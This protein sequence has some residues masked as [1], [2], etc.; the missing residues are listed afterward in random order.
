MQVGETIYEGLSKMGSLLLHFLGNQGR[1]P[2]SPK[3][4]ILEWV[5]IRIA[6]E[7]EVK[8]AWISDAVMKD[9]H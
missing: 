3:T 5:W 4:G 7:I 9:G 1:V 2:G 6:S 8:I